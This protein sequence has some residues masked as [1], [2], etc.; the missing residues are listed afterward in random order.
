MV[1][2]NVQDNQVDEPS[3][4][5]SQG[6]EVVKKIKEKIEFIQERERMV[7]KGQHVRAHKKLQ[8]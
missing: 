7:G 1:D 5:I 2:S 3:H 4:I 6:G 8:I